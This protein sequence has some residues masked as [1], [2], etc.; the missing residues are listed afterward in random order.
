MQESD[1]HTSANT[2]EHGNGTLRTDDLVMFDDK[3]T[4][5][6]SNDSG[7]ITFDDHV[8]RPRHRTLSLHDKLV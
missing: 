2:N 5:S 8:H 3:T 6:S 7:H 1:I 4:I